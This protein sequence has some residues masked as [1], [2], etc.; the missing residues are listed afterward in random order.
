MQN[1]IQPEEGYN[2]RP[3]RNGIKGR[4]STL[5]QGAL[6]PIQVQGFV[7]K[8]K[9]GGI[10]NPA[11]W[12]ENTPTNV[13]ELINLFLEK[14]IVRIYA[15]YVKIAYLPDCNIF[16]SYH[17][18]IIAS[19]NLEPEKNAELE[20]VKKLILE[21]AEI[22]EIENLVQLIK[23]KNS[24]MKQG[25]LRKVIEKILLEACKELPFR[26]MR[27]FIRELPKRGN[28]FECPLFK[29]VFKKPEGYEIKI[30]QPAPTATPVVNLG[31]RLLPTKKKSLM[32]GFASQRIWTP[33]GQGLLS[34]KKLKGET[35]GFV[36][37][38]HLVDGAF[39]A[40]TKAK[41]VNGYLRINR[42]LKDEVH[43]RGDLR[44]GPNLFDG[45][46]QSVS[47][48]SR[49]SQPAT[50]GT[51][52]RSL[53]RNLGQ[54]KIDDFIQEKAGSPK[55]KE[56]D[57]VRQKG[58]SQMPGLESGGNLSPKSQ[59]SLSKLQLMKEKMLEKLR[60]IELME[61]AVKNVGG[62]GNGN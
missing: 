23:V 40:K 25:E 33:F 19:W 36:G 22:R 13:Q 59:K 5:L 28:L 48:I 57:N 62:V 38:G 51:S 2:N 11:R 31:K 47:G 43:Q 29:N 9:D 7:K 3:S 61:Q 24:D 10:D 35:I 26:K 32:P 20:K 16:T 42:A 14:V 34:E 1:L 27:K 15:F 46:T 17:K 49:T 6:S 45:D 44:T 18:H 60:Q 41:S 8:D 53:A 30:P 50:V 4:P 55:Q 12:V 39:E 56:S 37:Q 58:D 52:F 21:D 54:L